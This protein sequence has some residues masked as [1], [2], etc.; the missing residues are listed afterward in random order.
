[1]NESASEGKVKLVLK[2]M[3][4]SFHKSKS[5]AIRF[6]IAAKLCPKLI[7]AIILVGNRKGFL[8]DSVG[9]AITVH[10]HVTSYSQ[11]VMFAFKI[12]TG[13]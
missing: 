12:R 1:V 3:S 6:M 8:C 4:R 10:F 7:F 2:P 11:F 5:F 13:V 9:I